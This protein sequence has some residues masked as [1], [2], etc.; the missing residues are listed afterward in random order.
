M[1]RAEDQ[2][3]LLR[4]YGDSRFAC[5]PDVLLGYRQN[6]L[7]MKSVLA[8]RRSLAQSVIRDALRRRLYWRI[9]L[10]IAGQAAKGLI[11]W[12]IVS[13]KLERRLL[14]HRALPISDEALMRTWRLIWE[15]VMTDTVGDGGV[16]Q[17]GTGEGAD[18]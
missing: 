18:L 2:D 13:L 14:R 10:A 12:G 4:S 8:G 17:E 6:T 5:L 16:A 7:P 11:E 15:R 9:P 3:L 1:L